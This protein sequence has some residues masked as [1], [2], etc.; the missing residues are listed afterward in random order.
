MGNEYLAFNNLFSISSNLNFFRCEVK[1]SVAKF[2]ETSALFITDS[3]QLW[4]SGDQSQINVKSDQPKKVIFFDGRI[5][6][7]VACG[8]DFYVA[9]VRRIVKNENE[10]ESFVPEAD[11]S[12]DLL[13]TSDSSFKTASTLAENDLTFEGIETP[14]RNVIPLS[15]DV[16]SDLSENFEELELGESE[17]IVIDSLQK[18][19]SEE[20]LCSTST[21]SSEN[22]ITQNNLSSGANLL[23]QTG[24]NA[25]STEL[26][27]WGD[28][29]YGQLGVGDIINRSVPRELL[30]LKHCGVRK[31]ACGAYHTLA[32]TLDGR[33]FAWG[34]NNFMQ[35]SHCSQI[36]QKSPQLF[37]SNFFIHLQSNE[38]AKDVAAGSY[39]S[40]IMM[41]KNVYLV[42]KLR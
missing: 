38:R 42:G 29:K 32:L 21:L 10:T 33:V 25:L 22:E 17:K 13:N 36:D 18:V 7:D 6:L 11:T 26:W 15:R 20:L 23:I 27:T 24:K 31:I 40:L 9:L 2:N 30:K 12:V 16:N 1:V 39:H 37:A 19:L 14:L 35:V 8:A 4:A 5:V 3:G 34:R 28:S 41:E